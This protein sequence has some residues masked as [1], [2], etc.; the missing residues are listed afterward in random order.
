LIQGGAV[1]MKAMRRAAGWRVIVSAAALLPAMSPPA[2]AEEA[3]LPGVN[4]VVT[5][6]IATLPAPLTGKPGDAKEGAKAVAGRRLGNCLSCH[7]IGALRE[8][9]FHGDVGPPLD[10]IAGRWDTAALRMIVVNA[11]MVFGAET[12]MPAFYR[13]GGLNRVRPEFAG[14]PILTAQQVEDVVAFL[15]TLK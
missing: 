12:V 2:L 10:G 9:E 14:K 5:G 13:T 3:G 4:I 15:A 1:S 6:G 7:A 11:K 8:E